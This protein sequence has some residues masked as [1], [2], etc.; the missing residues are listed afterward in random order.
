MSQSTTTKKI[1]IRATVQRHWESEELAAYRE[2]VST[3][4]QYMQQHRAQLASGEELWVDCHNVPVAWIEDG[5]IQVGRER[6][7]V[8]PLDDTYH[9]RCT[10]VGCPMDMAYCR[11]NHRL[12]IADFTYNHLRRKAQAALLP[13]G[14]VIR[15]SSPFDFGSVGKHDTFRKAHYAHGIRKGGVTRKQASTVFYTPD[16]H[17]PYRI[18]NWQELDWEIVSLPE[19]LA[20]EE[21]PPQAS[22]A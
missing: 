7:A 14:A 1:T 15:F 9:L 2:R 17:G 20:D 21:Q 5:C 3:D 8:G 4:E 13:D 6:Y 16:G 18:I 12:R 11:V 19:S 22:R 10:C